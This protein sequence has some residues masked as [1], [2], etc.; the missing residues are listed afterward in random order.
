MGEHCSYAALKLPHNL[1]HDFCHNA[2]R[3]LMSL[4]FHHFS[5]IM[6]LSMQSRIT[7]EKF[8]ADMRGIFKFDEDDEFTMKW[9][10]E[11]GESG[12]ERLPLI[13][14]SFFLTLHLSNFDTLLILLLLVIILSHAELFEPMRNLSFSA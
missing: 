3:S 13:E 4:F 6:V 14:V 5:T 12:G 11:E 7:L 8:C 10:D 9:L 1:K 2:I